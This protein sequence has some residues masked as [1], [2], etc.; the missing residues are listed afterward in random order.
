MSAIRCTVFGEGKAECDCGGRDGGRRRQGCDAYYRSR[1]PQAE[2]RSKAR[3]SD[4]NLSRSQTSRN[5]ESRHFETKSEVPYI[6]VQLCREGTVFVMKGG[7]LLA[8]TALL[9]SAQAVQAQC[10]SCKACHFHGKCLKG[11]GITKSACAGHGGTWCN[12]PF[13]PSPPPP[14]PFGPPPPPASGLHFEAFHYRG[15]GNLK[16]YGSPL[17]ESW[18][19]M[20]PF[21]VH[22]EHAK[23]LWYSNDKDFSREI[24]HMEKTDLYLMRFTGWV[25]IPSGGQWSFKTRSDDGSMLYIDGKVVVD[26][27]GLHGMKTKAGKTTLSK[28]W[29]KLVIT[30]YENNGGAGLQVSL[31]APPVFGSKLK[32][33]KMTAGMTKPGKDVL[34]KGSEPAAPPPPPGSGLHFEAFHLTHGKKVLLVLGGRCAA[35]AKHTFTVPRCL[36]V[37]TS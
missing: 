14:D 33:Q 2:D 37:P 7:L 11:N 1:S 26:N 28:G 32:W 9:L 25:S 20:K 5:L 18:K 22:Q 3:A 30:F 12:N 36:T 21:L 27:D 19:G 35:L 4:H 15:H 31:A 17:Y 23:D 16:A 13:G 10:G 6:P 34:M 8:T 24:P 29:H